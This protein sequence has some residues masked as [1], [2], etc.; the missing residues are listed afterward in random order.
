VLLNIQDQ[1]HS[2]KG[3]RYKVNG[4]YLQEKAVVADLV[5]QWQ[6]LPPSLGFF[7]KLRRVVKWYRSLYLCRAKEHHA[8][9]AALRTHMAQAQAA[10]QAMPDNVTHQDEL[11]D[12]LESLRNFEEWRAEGQCIRSS[13]RWRATGDRG[14]RKFFKVVR[15]RS[16]QSTLV[17]LEDSN[18][19][20]RS[21]S[22]DLER[23]YK[24]FYRVLYTKRAA[25]PS[26]PE[27]QQ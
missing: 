5:Q 4:H 17:E 3:G 6:R 16:S 22:N 14:S 1:A 21:S 12:I 7:G 20:L 24:D 18:G 8:S 27:N 13:I 2:P 9:K 19:V 15:T 23:V 11:A 26:V 25:S 10:L